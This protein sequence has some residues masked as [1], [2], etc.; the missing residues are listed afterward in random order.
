MY[1]IRRYWQWFL[2][3]ILL[4]LVVWFVQYS[5]PL[6]IGADGFLHGRMAIMVREN[7]FLQ[8]LPQAYF[9]WFNTPRFS[10]KDFLYHLYLIPFVSTLGFIGGTKIGAFI[11]TSV[12]YFSVLWCIR[13]TTRFGWVGIV[14]LLLLCSGQFLRDSAEARPFVF[15]MVLTLL[16]TYS[17]AKKSI[18]WVFIFSLLYGM[19][20]LSAWLLPLLAVAVSVWEWTN[21]DKIHTNIYLASI[22]GYVVSFLLHPNFPNNFFYFYLNGILVP[23]YAA[24]TGVLELGAEFFPLYTHEVI[25][26]F[27]GLI[28]GILLAG[29]I[30]IIHPP[31]VQRDVA[32]WTLAVFLLGFLGLVSKRNMTHLYPVFVVWLGVILGSIY[33][34]LKEENR[35]KKARMIV[36]GSFVSIVLIIYS[37]WTTIP[38]LQMSLLG[39]RVYGDHFSR[40]GTFLNANVPPGARVFHTNWSDTQFLIGVAPNYEYIE[41][42]DPIY[43]YNFNPDLYKLYRSVSFGGQSDIYKVLKESFGAS[44]GYAGKNYFNAFIEQVRKD[45]R[46]TILGEDQLG[47][48]FSVKDASTSGSLQKSP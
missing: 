47:I 34:S 44:Y 21:K 30:S 5:Q 33:E 31:K 18:K 15:A 1:L 22:G 4:V 24:K 39:D 40:V 19:T 27:P 42:L 35:V 13:K 29:F 2:P 32:V 23:L 12:L 45:T 17:I 37:A 28:G 43:M 48:V 41:T 14:S 25:R 8:R 36:V 9:S 11:T 10:D 16:G 7:G 46:F 20:H 6:I 26:S 3:G 38:I